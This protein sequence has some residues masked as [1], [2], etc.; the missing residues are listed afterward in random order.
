M[1]VDMFVIGFDVIIIFVLIFGI[2]CLRVFNIVFGCF[3][4]LSL[5]GVEVEGEVL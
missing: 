3:V 4:V 2:Y 5:V 1:V